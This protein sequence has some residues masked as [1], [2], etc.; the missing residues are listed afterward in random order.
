M[1]SLTF[2]ILQWPYEEIGYEITS[3]HFASA[4]IKPDGE[5]HHFSGLQFALQRNK[6]YKCKGEW[7]IIVSF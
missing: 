7:P 2:H 4:V 1:M 5:A 3:P 6:M